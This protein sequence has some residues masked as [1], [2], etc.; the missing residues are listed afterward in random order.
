M[1]TLNLNFTFPDT[2]AKVSSLLYPY[3]SSAARRETITAITNFINEFYSGSISLTTG[4]QS[5]GGAFASGTATFSGQPTAITDSLTINGV[6][7]GFVAS[8]ATGT[9]V[10]IGANLAATLTNFV[11]V[12][13]TNKATNA[14]LINLTIAASATVLTVTSTVIGTPSNLIPLAKTSTVI[15]LSAATLTGGTAATVTTF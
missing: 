13:N 5:R 6:S 1:G 15:T 10:N 4:T 7:F 12:F 3:P 2:D 11:T 8:G 9:Q 14:A